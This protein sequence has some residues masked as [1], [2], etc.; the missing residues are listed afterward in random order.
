MELVEFQNKIKDFK[1][2]G[3]SIIGISYD[4]IKVLKAFSEQ[5]KITYPLL[6]DVGSDVIRKYGIL[7][8]NID[9]GKKS[10]GIPYPGLYFIN[11]NLVVTGKEFEKAYAARPTAKSVLVMHFDEKIEFNVKT[12]QNDYVNG[13]VGI[14]D[15]TARA[16]QVLAMIA[17][18]NMKN[19]FHLYGTPIPQGYIPLTIKME[20]NPNFTLDSLQFPQTKTLRLKSLNETFQILPGKIKLKSFLR[21]KKK[22]QKGFYR[23]R[24]NISL[25]ACDDKTCRF[26]ENFKLEFPLRIY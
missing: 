13:Q 9:P 12:F 2:R 25:Q 23:I 22:P 24:I 5:H 19:G 6:S 10:Y 11:Q 21:I 8:T 4:S 1:S 26:P 3:I 18:L 7:N 16:A 20:P 15:T 17:E 14:S